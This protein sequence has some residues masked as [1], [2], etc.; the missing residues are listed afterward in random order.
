MPNPWEFFT[1]EQIAEVTSC[2]LENVQANW[3]RLTAQLDL[4]GLNERATQVAMIGTVA[5]ESASTFLPVREAFYLGE[6]EPAE[7]YRKTLWYYPH[8]GRG[9]IQCS[10]EGNYRA[11]GQKIA[12]L[13]GAGADD[14]TFDLIANPDNMLDPD[15]SAAFAALYFRDTKTVQGYGIVDAARAGDWEWVRRLVQGGTAQLDRLI[16]IANALGE[17]PVPLPVTLTYNPDLPP[18][19]QIQNWVCAIRAATWALKS[20]GVSIDAGAMQDD[21][22]AHGE[23]HPTNGGGGLQDHRGYGLADAL[24]RH[25]PDGTKVEVMEV[26]SWDD[27]AYR[28]GRGPLCIGSVSLNHWLNVAKMIGPDMFSSPNPAPNYPTGSPIG[29]E[30]NRAEFDAW[31]PWSA[32]FVEVLPAPAQVDLANLVGNAFAENGVVVPAL[33]GAL[34]GHDWTQVEAVIKWLRENRPAA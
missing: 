3:P 30:L 29:D 16:S 18:E 20:V 1:A 28:T 22:V 6:P 26:A 8:Y 21:M 10:L 4:C 24:R 2:P 5:I 9:F 25:L 31:A 13:W 19:R 12:A 33:V 23:E 17:A 14:P 7:S 32:V 15:M 11:Y 27:L 34:N